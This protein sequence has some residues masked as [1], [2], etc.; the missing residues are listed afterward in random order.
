VL[1]LTH[2]RLLCA[3]CCVLCAVCCVPCA[4][5]RVLCAVCRVLCVRWTCSR[6][7]F[8]GWAS[9]AP[10]GFASHTPPRPAAATSTPTP[11]AQLGATSAAAPPAQQSCPAQHPVAAQQ[12]AERVD[13]QAVYRMVGLWERLRSRCGAPVG[14]SLRPGVPLDVL[15]RTPPSL[16]ERLP[17][18]IIASLLVHDGQVDGGDHVGLLFAGARLLSLREIAAA[19]TAG[20]DSLPLTTVVGFQHV[21]VRTDG[22][23]CMRAG[24]NEHVKAASWA[25]F[26]ERVLWD[27]V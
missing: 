6:L 9:A 20:D 3:V 15:S 5:C 25:A 7:G 12:L 24:F 2:G 16:L 23:V 17:R 18:A 22:R 1:R 13:W 26:L 8:E 14:F 19:A 27:T 11:A 4:V 10:I 21:A